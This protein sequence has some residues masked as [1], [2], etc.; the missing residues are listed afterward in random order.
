MDGLR[1]NG[2]PP[3][4]EVRRMMTEGTAG[5]KRAEEGKEVDTGE[6]FDQ[7]AVRNLPQELTQIQSPLEVA[8]ALRK[9]YP[10]V[11]FI[12][13]DVDKYFG[14][15]EDFAA[16]LGQGAFI[17]VSPDVLDWMGQGSEAWKQGS[18]MISQALCQ[19]MRDMKAGAYNAGAVIGDQGEITCW[20]AEVTGDK[21]SPK[22]EWEQEAENIRNM[23]DR[24]EE[25]RKKNAERMKK[26]RLTQ[27]KKINY[28]MG[29]DM[30]RLARGTNDKAVRSLISRVYAARGR[31]A[32]SSAYDKKEIQSA[33]A[34]MDHVIRCARTKIRQLK[35]EEQIDFRRKKAQKNREEKLKRELEKELK[36]R[37][38]ARRAK[39][40]ARI[41]ERLP[42]LPGLRDDDDRREARE[43]AMAAAAS[44]GLDMSGAGGAVSGGLEAA[45]AAGGS[46]AVSA[47]AGV[48]VQ[49]TVSTI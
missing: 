42:D 49:V 41:F 33:V 3:Y 12:F 21:E 8:E 32:G 36:E 31:I 46:P 16:G 4:G 38:R 15:I 28:Q 40:H 37:R 43:E 19:V 24:L 1:M 35:E 10:Q 18:E 2:V 44:A 17:L 20:K 14:N 22:Q 9:Q 34:Q 13:A 11:N 26:L 48:A 27:K 5:G 30:A 29:R 47:D 39:E 23:L 6:V 25:S 45:G 7:N